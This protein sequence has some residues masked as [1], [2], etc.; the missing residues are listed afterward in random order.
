MSEKR[1]R[2]TAVLLQTKNEI[3]KNEKYESCF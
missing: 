1:L 2:S 3:E